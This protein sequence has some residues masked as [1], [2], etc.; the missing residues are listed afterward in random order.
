MPEIGTLGLTRR[1]LETCPRESDC[2]PERKRRSIHRPPTGGAP[3]LDPTDERRLE[4]EPR[5]GVRHRHLAKAAGNSYPLP[6]YRHR[7]SRR[8]YPVW[9]PAG[10]SQNAP[11]ASG[12]IRAG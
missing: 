6:P 8:L 11:S 2:G 7:A 10:P 5:R 4:T 12:E 1:E 9:M 3:A